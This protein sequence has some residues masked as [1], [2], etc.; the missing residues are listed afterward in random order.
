MFSMHL[1]TVLEPPVANQM[2][3]AATLLFNLLL[4]S[5]VLARPELIEVSAHSIV[6]IAI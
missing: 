5:G 4:G 6:C 2:D 3:V 1:C